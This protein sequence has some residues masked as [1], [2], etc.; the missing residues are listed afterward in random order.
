VPVNN[1]LWPIPSRK[2]ARIVRNTAGYRT[3]ID[4]CVS[5]FSE[6]REACREELSLHN[7]SETHA[8]T[9]ALTIA[10]AFDAN[11][12]LSHSSNNN[13]IGYEGIM[14]EGV[15]RGDEQ[16]IPVSD[17]IRQ[18]SFYDIEYESDY[19]NIFKAFFIEDATLIIDPETGRSNT[20]VRLS[21][22]PFKA[23]NSDK[24]H[25]RWQDFNTLWNYV[26]KHRFIPHAWKGGLAKICHNCGGIAGELTVLDND[27][28]YL[29][30]A[31]YPIKQCAKN[32]FITLKLCGESDVPGCLASHRAD[33]ID[34]WFITGLTARTKYAYRFY[35]EQ[36][37]T[38]TDFRLLYGKN[39][40]ARYDNST[41]SNFINW[42]YL[43]TSSELEENAF[44]AFEVKYMNGF[45]VSSFHA[46]E[47]DIV[48]LRNK[49]SN[50]V[51][52]SNWQ[53]Q[54][55]APEHI[56][57]LI[58]FD[59]CRMKK[60]RENLNSRCR[61]SLHP[62]EL[63]FWT[64]DTQILPTYIEG[65]VSPVLPSKAGLSIAVLNCLLEKSPCGGWAWNIKLKINPNFSQKKNRWRGSVMRLNPSKIS[66]ETYAFSVL[67]SNSDT[68]L[69]HVGP[70][71]LA[72]KLKPVRGSYITL[73][74]LVDSIGG[75]Y[76]K[77]YTPRGRLCADFG[78]IVGKTSNTFFFT[79]TI[80]A[81]P[82]PNHETKAMFKP[83]SKQIAN[84][85]VWHKLCP[86][87][88]SDDALSFR[89]ALDNRI[90]PGGI[91]LPVSSCTNLNENNWISTYVTVER[92]GKYSWSIISQNGKSVQQKQFWKNLELFFPDLG[93]K[94]HIIKSSDN[95]IIIDRQLNKQG[96]HKAIITPGFSVPMFVASGNST[97][98][99][100]E[101]TLPDNVNLPANIFL[102]GYKNN[103]LTNNENHC[104]VL[105]WNFHQHKWQK[106]CCANKFNQRDFMKIG[107]ITHN[108]ISKNKKIRLQ[109][110]AAKSQA[111]IRGIYILPN[112]LNGKVNI[113][114]TSVSNL[115][116]EF[117]L[118]ISLAQSIID[119]AKDN[120]LPLPDILD[121]ASVPET[122]Y[123]K[124]LNGCSTR[125]D[126]FTARLE[127]EVVRAEKTLAIRRCIALL[128]RDWSI[129]NGD[130][131][132][133]IKLKCIKINNKK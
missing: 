20:R 101:W 2:A 103:S 38:K 74:S 57:V 83:V 53:W 61:F 89:R 37:D 121:K 26:S 12:A 105:A 18:S 113:R 22:A 40:V 126:A 62:E 123:Y 24:L 102:L 35:N 34:V 14:L 97:S 46:C 129:K 43:E 21:D 94:T 8:D 47:P 19:M 39:I 32:N 64:T 41:N 49:K 100:F 42:R 93:E 56:E 1:F 82:L 3:I 50:P 118:D 85:P 73:G 125:S 60:K 132:S 6:L 90:S 70:R 117:C 55:K 86:K 15:K 65:L 111:W 58:T 119:I 36:D 80:P 23:R 52:V 128:V 51:Y 63:W 31:G 92:K 99:I 13:T 9:L 98:G 10:D 84:S 68:L 88:K 96:K 54:R 122:L 44:I 71:K 69:V 30:F 67:K 120:Y 45:S 108:N 11:I 81:A 127:V 77:L 115:K 27:T 66:K 106:K 109:I 87:E 130:L 72:E 17:F 16:V 33:G 133:D 107:L 4:P 116:D 131:I 110:I 76:F 28:N 124:L 5:S 25:H 59:S 29:Y 7:F 78:S 48:A 112:N 91:L 75:N 114:T 104:E 95:N 79:K